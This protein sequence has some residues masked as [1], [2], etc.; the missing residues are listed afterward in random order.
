M[1]A[2]YERELDTLKAVLEPLIQ[3]FE[4]LAPLLE[5]ERAA[6]RAR[7]V[8]KIGS[9]S[10]RIAQTLVDIHKIDQE[11]Q[12]LTL[13]L[14][15]RLG[16]SRENLD[17]SALDRA[18]G[19]DS[20]LLQVRERLRDAI[21]KAEAGNRENQAVYA[22]VMTATESLLRALKEGAQGPPSSYNR[23]GSRQAT[24]RIHF[25]SKQL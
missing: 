18:L 21:G 7:E 24:S 8:E 5:E 12:E 9:L 16:L 6:L 2:G 13:V 14:G 19:G 10:Q 11:R 15:G 1:I 23:L 17:L 22:G 4:A 25:L 20:G 3:H